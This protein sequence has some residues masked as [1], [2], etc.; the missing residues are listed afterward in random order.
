MKESSPDNSSGIR[1][2]KHEY[3]SVCCITSNSNNDEIEE[4]YKDFYT[5]INRG[6]SNPCNNNW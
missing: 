2:D 4:V 3:N 1:A 5:I 6:K